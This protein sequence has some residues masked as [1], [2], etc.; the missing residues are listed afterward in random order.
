MKA[1]ISA[2]RRAG[3]ENRVAQA[4][5]SQTQSEADVIWRDLRP[6]LDEE[7]NQLPEKYRTP[8][9]L[10]YLQGKTY[11][12]AARELGWTR[13][14]L[15]GRM[16]QARDLLRQRLVRRG[17]TLTAALLPA[18]L[19]P[20]AATAMVPP[21]LM[22]STW[23]GLLDLVAGKA[24]GFLSPQ[25][26]QLGESM[27][28]AMVL[29]KVKLIAGAALAATLLTLTTV[30]A[31]RSNPSEPK[32]GEIRDLPPQHLQGRPTNNPR[33]RVDLV[34][35]PLPPQAVSRLGT[36]RWR[37][38][39]AVMTVA[40]D[41]HG[42][43]I[44]S[45][46]FDY[47][48]RLWDPATGKER[49][50][51]PDKTGSQ[52][53]WAIAYSSDGKLLA[54]AGTTIHLLDP[55]RG[56]EVCSFARLPSPVHALTF[57]PDGK[58]LAAVH[59]DQAFR[60]WDTETGR[61]TNSL[62]VEHRNVCSVAFSSDGKTLAT[63]QGDGDICLWDR[64][65]GKKREE[66]E[67]HTGPVKAVAFSPRGGFLA[68]AGG[69]CT[70][71][72]WE[73]AGGR[74][75]HRFEDVPVGML[76]SLCFSPNGKWLT[77]APGGRPNASPLQLK[78]WNTAS[79]KE[80]HALPGSPGGGYGAAFLP[81]SN[82]L[83][84]AGA[85]GNTV[86]FWDLARGEETRLGRG[87]QEQVT[88]VAFAPNGRMLATASLDR[89]VRLWDS[90]T[91]TELRQLP[92]AS[93]VQALAYSPTGRLLASAR[94]D[95][96][97]YLWN[98]ATG[99][100]VCRLPVQEEWIYALAFSPDGGTLAAT[101]KAIHRWQVP[102]AR[103]LPVFSTPPSRALGVG[104]SPDGRT[105]ASGH[106]D[107]R[108]CLWDAGSGKLL[109]RLEGSRGMVPFVVFSPDGQQLVSSGLDETVRLWDVR[110]AREIRWL[111]RD[112]K[113]KQLM[114][115]YCC[116]AYSPDGKTLATGS[117][118]RTIRLYDPA[119]GRQRR[120]IAGHHQGTINALAFSPDGKRLA[121]GSQ[122]TTV[123]VWDLS[124]A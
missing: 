80:E 68:S 87:H 37:H 19:S 106:E 24:G 95:S 6:V 114:G 93:K 20:A 35:D 56:K 85:F 52:R 42:K 71:R 63:G 76:Q 67:G 3:R 50:R 81:E 119:T 30:W 113:E 47:V 15:S 72:L 102:E 110:T 104:F 112:S 45:V 74:E 28:R 54:A 105:I 41:P 103:E 120:R 48:V 92:H 53:L 36:I 64:S 10:C 29:T 99:K 4:A 69:D 115:N 12:E 31:V 107:H 1:K 51:F 21:V 100:E 78:V 55:L 38:G 101:G 89:T 82:T 83:V 32:A 117:W 124:G 18:A 57:S 49:H 108:I 86:R 16:D 73:V 121:S 91:G 33:L 60:F 7:L 65:T 97:V 23:R 96:R 25:V 44:A 11:S 111:V 2:V 77:F 94:D 27:S 22:E 118:D 17:V 98:P 26:V 8:M 75:V 46:G 70:V 13:G 66:L 84:S 59:L 43:T 61:E 40:V 9:V 88:A 123:L 58:Q 90:A 14:T 79:G 5:I 116:V 109:C 39:A 122:D 62:P 34:G